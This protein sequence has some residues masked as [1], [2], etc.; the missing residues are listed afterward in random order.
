MGAT[1][2]ANTA[3]LA[4]FLKNGGNDLTFASGT[5]PAAGARLVFEYEDGSGN[6]HLTLVQLA[7][8][9]VDTTSATPVDIVELI[10]VA[11]TASLQHIHLT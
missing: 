4:T 11:S 8:G 6:A 10:G 3:A 5:V 7:Y 1:T 2:F 9:A